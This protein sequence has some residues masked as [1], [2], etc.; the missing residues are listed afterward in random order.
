MP[1]KG[2]NIYK[3]K[4]GRW[5][6][7]FIESRLPDGKIKY[8]SVYG[9]TYAEVKYKLR[10]CNLYPKKTNINTTVSEWIYNYVLSLKDK[11]KISTYCIYMRYIN[12]YIIPFFKKIKLKDLTKNV[13]QSFVN[14]QKELSSSTIKGIFSTVKEALKS[15]HNEGYIDAVWIGVELPKKKKSQIDVFSKEEQKLIENSLNITDTPNEIGVLLCLYTGLRLGEV[16]G[17]KWSDIN[18]QS[19]TLSVNRTVQ[20]ISIDGKSQLMELPPKSESSCRR[21]PI[22]YFLAE[23]LKDIKIISSGSYILNLNSHVMD[24]RTY[25]NQY[26]NILKRAGVRYNNFHNLRHTFSVRALELGFDIKT[27]SEI[28]GHSDATV[29]L[30]IYSHS[31]DEHKRSSM[32]KLSGLRENN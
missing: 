14:S 3:R 22:P 28:L 27:L 1:R 8:H 20:R 13:L 16:C 6:G 2:E 17:L 15:A 19:C 23:H 11:V 31:L 29:T 18:F 21:I 7:R 4:D 5:E 26:K 24:P 9:K 30:Q 10:C 12:N 25:Q 32:E